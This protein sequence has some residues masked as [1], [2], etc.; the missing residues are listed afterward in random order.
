M[1][2]SNFTLDTFYGEWQKYQDSIKAAIAPLTDEQLAL[3]A[4]PNLRSIGDLAM[5]VIGARVSWFVEFLGESDAV[6]NQL[7]PDKPTMSAAELV[8]DM[9]VTWK[10]MADCLA[11]W[12][13]ADM[14]IT[15]PHEWRGDNYELSRSWVV[16]HILEHDLHHGG[17]ISLTLGIHGLQAPDI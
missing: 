11:R 16:W 13:S 15:F 9:D 17:E 1:A 3:R 2:E 8:K 6:L 5:H 12:S 10:M 7:T 14:Q 4:A